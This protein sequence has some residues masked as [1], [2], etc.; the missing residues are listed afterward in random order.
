[1]SFSSDWLSL[2][3]SADDAAR[4][5]GLLA[6]LADWAREVP[7]P[8]EALDLGEDAMIAIAKDVDGTGRGDMPAAVSNPDAVRSGQESGRRP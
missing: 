5:R 1:M 6:A 2:R 8:L 4:D 7:G 3:E